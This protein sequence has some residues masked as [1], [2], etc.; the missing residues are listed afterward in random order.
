MTNVTW[1]FEAAIID[2][3]IDE[4]EVVIGLEKDP[5][6][7]KRDPD[8]A[9]PDDPKSELLNIDDEASKLEPLLNGVCGLELVII[10]AVFN[11]EEELKEP[12]DEEPNN[13]KD[14]KP[15]IKL[16]PEPPEFCTELPDPAPTN[17]AVVAPM[18]ED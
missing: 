9:E 6:D 10:E 13:A 3:A 1:E 17:D 18:G 14:D 15:A 8:K 2:I 16:D 7:A 11:T 4:G 5:E 12:N